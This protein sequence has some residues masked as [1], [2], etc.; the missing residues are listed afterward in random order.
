MPNIIVDNLHSKAIDCRNKK[1]KVLDLLL[2]HMDWMHAC[3]AKGRCTSCKGVFLSGIASVS[4]PTG[5]EDKFKA[6]GKLKDNERLCCQITLGNEDI[7][8]RVP[9]SNKLPHMNYS[10]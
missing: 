6:L 3:G 7:V 10:S 4:A 9:D 5:A 2:E 8:I 1:E